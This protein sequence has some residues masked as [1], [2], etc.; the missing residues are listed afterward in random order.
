[1]K[2]ESSQIEANFTKFTQEDLTPFEHMMIGSSEDVV[3]S[4]NM[5]LVNSES[6]ADLRGD[7]NAL[8][9]ILS[10]TSLTRV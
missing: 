7:K 8:R 4:G 2:E 1:M 3:V 10:P 5:V 9:Q 6:L